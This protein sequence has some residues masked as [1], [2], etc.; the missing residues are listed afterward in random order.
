M[1]M[2]TNA[3]NIRNRLEIRTC[4]TEDVDSLFRVV[5]EPEF[6]NTYQK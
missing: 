2:F 4:Q 3:R 6:F 5:S 1:D